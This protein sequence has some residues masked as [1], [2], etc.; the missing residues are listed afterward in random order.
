MKKVSTLAVPYIVWAVL[1]LAI[2]MI[3]ILFY[4][5]TKD[6]NGILKVSFKFLADQNGLVADRSQHGFGS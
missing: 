1:M 2:P 3:L 6:G 4:S 5:A